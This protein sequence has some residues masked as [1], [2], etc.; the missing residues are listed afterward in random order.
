MTVPSIDLND[1]TSIPQ[2]GF[3]V[4]KVPAT[5]TFDVV[6]EAIRVGYRHID[7][8]KAYENEAEVGRAVRESG[9]PREEFYVTTKLW[10]DD[11]GAGNVAPAFEASAERL[12]IDYVDLYLM[13]W[14]SPWRG[15]YIESWEAMNALKNTHPVRSVGVSNFT[16]THIKSLVDAGLPAPPVNQIELHPGLQQREATTEG[17]VYNIATEAWS[18]LA[19]GHVL[20]DPN[21]AAIAGR[22]S[23][24]PAQVI[25]RWHVQNDRI[26]IP[27]SVNPARIA[28]NFAIFDFELS[29]DDVAALDSL[30][31]GKRYGP[32]PDTAKF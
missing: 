8:A 30:E 5:D 15:L 19:H 14:P 13:H 18:P 20:E 11:Q 3:G 1:G 25:L 6:S 24:T 28:E 16:A 2:L 26:V 12:D 7:T 21:I 4:F 17:S 9:I 10:N 22:V 32:N 31:S 29:E 23:R 27:K